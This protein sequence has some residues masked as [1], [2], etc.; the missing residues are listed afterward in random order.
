LFILGFLLKFLGLVLGASGGTSHSNLGY[1]GAVR[2]PRLVGELPVLRDVALEVYEAEIV[3]LVGS[4]GAGKT[5]FLRG[6]RAS[7]PGAD[8]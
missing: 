7:C 6:C 3:A 2:L 1:S 5:T 4:N 8:E